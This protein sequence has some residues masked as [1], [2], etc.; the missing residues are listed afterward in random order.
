MQKRCVNLLDSVESSLDR[1]LPLNSRYL[2]A[3]GYHETNLWE[4]RLLVESFYSQPHGYLEEEIELHEILEK[5]RVE[6]QV[7]EI[8]AMKSR[9]QK[10]KYQLDDRDS[11]AAVC[12]SQQIEVV[13]TVAKLE[14]SRID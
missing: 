9:L 14:C 7:S 8:K 6:K 2:S 4:M 10:L 13:S 5:L 1:V 12:R 3:A 11:V